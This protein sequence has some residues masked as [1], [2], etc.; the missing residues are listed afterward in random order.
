MQQWMS[1][2]EMLPLWLATCSACLDAEPDASEAVLRPVGTA[3]RGSWP[4]DKSGVG[5][6]VRTAAQGAEGSQGQVSV[7]PDAILKLLIEV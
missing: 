6:V 5:A 1:D 4:G 3:Q 2:M 7:L